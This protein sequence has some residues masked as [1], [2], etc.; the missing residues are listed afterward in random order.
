[1][2]LRKLILTA[3]SLIILVTFAACGEE[4]PKDE[5]EPKESQDVEGEIEQDVV[6][7]V[8]GEEIMY[9]E[10]SQT[11]E[12]LAFQM[13]MPIDQLEEQDDEMM[14]ELR[15]MA[16]EELIGGTLLAQ[17][18]EAEGLTPDEEEVEKNLEQYTAQFGE[19]EEEI[20]E[21]LAQEDLTMEDL[22]EDVTQ[23]LM[24]TEIMDEKIEVDEDV[25]VSEEEVR[26]V[27]QQQQA[28]M[29]MMMGE[30]EED[31]DL[32]DFEDL[33]EEER[34]EMEEMAEQQKIQQLE[35]EKL[36][37]YIDELR[38]EGEVEVKI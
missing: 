7:V 16:M 10:L 24:I 37:E 35:H 3:L 22:R 28:Q 1:M 38:E 32:P 18:A 15:D 2:K 13:Q 6:A 36:M 19:S 31:A 30:K 12:Q 9:E 14:N 26:E 34:Q 33:E 4:A 20:E 23:S 8:N 25:D 11:K 29:Q 27:Y 5:A 21:N 17:E